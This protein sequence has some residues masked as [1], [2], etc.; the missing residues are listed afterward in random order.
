MLH[1]ASKAYKLNGNQVFKAVQNFHC[2]FS[3]P[4]KGT[5]LCWL[6]FLKQHP[7]SLINAWKSKS[8]LPYV[9]NLQ[10]PLVERERRAFVIFLDSRSLISSLLKQF[11]S[12]IKN[13]F[14]ASSDFSTCSC[15]LQSCVFYVSSSQISCH[16][17]LWSHC[18]S[19]EFQL[20]LTMCIGKSWTFVSVVSIKRVDKYDKKIYY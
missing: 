5:K 16:F 19:V 20:L 14:L 2:V 17:V 3:M 10:M 11:F 18:P 15:V 8:K 12:V 7:P 1:A 13:G 4:S 9:T 6:F